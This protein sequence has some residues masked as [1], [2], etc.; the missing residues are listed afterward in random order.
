M[1][2]GVANRSAKVLGAVAAAALFLAAV[3]YFLWLEPVSIDSGAPTAEEGQSASAD[4]PTRIGRAIVEESQFQAQPVQRAPAIDR[5]YLGISEKDLAL[6]KTAKE[7]FGTAIR[8]I[9]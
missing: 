4:T 5:R 7:N 3:C 9:E 6:L 2:P 8:L 1:V